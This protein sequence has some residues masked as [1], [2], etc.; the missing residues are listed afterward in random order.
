MALALKK[1]DDSGDARCP[2]CGA[3]LLPEAVIC[4]QCGY[5]LR[6][7]RRVDED[8]ASKRN[9]LTLVGV[10]LLV[11]LSVGAVAYRIVSPTSTPP[12]PVVQPAPAP[13][14]KT[15]EA[16]PPKGEEVAETNAA[17]SLAASNEN[18]VAAATTNLAVLT[19]EAPVETA[20]A[21]AV[22]EAQERPL[23]EAQLDKAAPL[24]AVGE[25][26]ELR[27][28]NGLVQRG[29]LVERTEAQVVVRI[30]SNQTRNMEFT[31]L[32]R[33]TRVRSDL[34]FR[35]KYIEHHTK[36]RVQKILT[37]TNA[38]NPTGRP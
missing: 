9:P 8:A 3:A 22:V 26:L 5:D 12:P 29:I 24:Y 18:A 15:P 21:P 20:P 31:L 34:Q 19:N 16:V 4:V 6:S 25:E 36:L 2:S 23:V 32:D 11:V 13:V 14:A 27:L 7:G 30:S 38:V 1:T 10:A 37:S 33:G 17:P 28:T 35:D